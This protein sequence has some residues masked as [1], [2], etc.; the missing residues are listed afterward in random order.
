MA[1]AVSKRAADDSEN[2]RDAL[3]LFRDL[4]EDFFASASGGRVTVSLAEVDIKLCGG[5]GD[6]VVTTL[7]TA[8]TTAHFGDTLHGENL[9][10]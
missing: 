9:L 6:H 1:D 3:E 7:S 5:H 8:Q 2:A 4:F 10:L